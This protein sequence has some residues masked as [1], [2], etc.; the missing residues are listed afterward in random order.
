M[1]DNGVPKNNSNFIQEVVLEKPKSKEKRSSPKI[2]DLYCFTL[3][4]RT[5]VF[6]RNDDKLQSKIKS[7]LERYK[8]FNNKEYDE[9][10]K[11]SEGV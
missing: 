4:D 7:F 6:F 1:K 8:Q 9:A 5:K 2:K 3:N 10:H 11:L